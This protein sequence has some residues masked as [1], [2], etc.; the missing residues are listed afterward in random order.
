MMIPLTRGNFAL[1]DE[2]DD[3]LNKFI[4]YTAVTRKTN[5]KWAAVRNGYNDTLQVPIYMHRV[6]MERKLNRK[7][8]SDELVDH[9]NQD[10]LSNI[11]DNR[12]CNLRIVTNR[13]NCQNQRKC[14]T[15]KSSKFKGVAWDKK[16]RKWRSRIHVN[17]KS[18]NLGFFINEIDAAKAYDDAANQHFGEFAKTNYG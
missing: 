8:R 16:Y 9:V 3:D 14:V 2:Q 12:R 17:G 4:W 15:P 1:V 6:I 10:N 5:N 11:I 7:L 18:I 13:Q